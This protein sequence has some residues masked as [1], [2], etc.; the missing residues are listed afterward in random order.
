MHLEEKVWS[1]IFTDNHETYTAQLG[2]IVDNHEDHAARELLQWK[3]YEAS[4]GSEK[5]LLI[6][7]TTV[8]QKGDAFEKENKPPQKIS[9]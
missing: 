4:A 2:K 8:Q 6:W 7:S 9:S 3:F 5:S 1:S